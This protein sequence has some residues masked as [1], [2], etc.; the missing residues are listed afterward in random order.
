MAEI[1]AK[2]IQELREKTAAG[3]LDCKKALIENN[4]ERY[5]RS[6]TTFSLLKARI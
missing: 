6:C 3:M 2:L 4:G 1:T 5:T